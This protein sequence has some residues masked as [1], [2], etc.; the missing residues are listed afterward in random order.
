MID[1]FSN[2]INRPPPSPVHSQSNHGGHSRPRQPSIP[3]IQE[4]ITYGG[5][6]RL[7]TS[8]LENLYQQQSQQLTQLQPGRAIENAYSFV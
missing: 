6:V 4:V 1:R 2:W 7:R 3:E 8:S 5:S